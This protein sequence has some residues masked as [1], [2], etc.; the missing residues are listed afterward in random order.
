M[1]FLVG[2]ALLVEKPKNVYMIEIENTHGDGDAETYTY[3]F[4]RKGDEKHMEEVVKFLKWAEENPYKR[5]ELAEKYADLHDNILPSELWN[6]G[7]NNPEELL[8]SDA[9]N[10][11]YWCK[12]RL[13]H[14]SWYD[15]KGNGFEVTV[16]EDI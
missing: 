3:F 14:I 4:F 5:D 16:N 6:S 12:P 10:E 9:T 11:G 1:K 8:D 7:L 15:R 13:N 2:N